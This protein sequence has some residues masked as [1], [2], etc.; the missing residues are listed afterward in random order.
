MSFWDKVWA[1]LGT[2]GAVQSVIDFAPRVV[3]GV[4]ALLLFLVLIRVGRRG[5]EALARRAG[6]DATLT[7]FIQT[8]IRYALGI[9]GT[10]TVLGQLGVDVTS[11]LTSLGVV[12]LTIGFAARDTLSN[13]ISGLFIL[14]D[15]PFV[16][17]D[18]IEI[19]G[20]YGRVDSI[21]LRSTRV[22]TVDGKML[23]IPNS[24]IVNSTVASYTNFPNL[25]LD[26]DITI[27]VNE[28]LS[29]VRALFLDEVAK[30]EGLLVEPRPPQMVLTAVND[31]N[32]AVQFRA[33]LDDE[34]QHVA[35]RF[36]FRERLFV[37]LRD[38]GIEMPFETIQLAPFVHSSP[39]AAP[40]KA[41]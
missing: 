37:R 13:L 5:V 33:W 32:L 25:R 16:I 3:A 21:T 23:A 28:D 38:E 40:E 35:R 15:R 29:R 9:I 10:L 26:V 39:K 20:S 11:I 34:K 14:W 17:G 1:G 4:L 19:G 41:A 8:V 18:L 2:E 27:G 31:Y 24:T 36:E 22:V 30:M 6:L 7:A 12:G